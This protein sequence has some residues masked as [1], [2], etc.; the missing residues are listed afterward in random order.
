M[1]LCPINHR[2][3]RALDNAWL[4]RDKAA[5]LEIA[6]LSASGL[7]R[8]SLQERLELARRYKAKWERLYN[9][10]FDEAFGP[11][12]IESPEPAQPEAI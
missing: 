12:E 4:W 2:R 1:R 5:D 6:L 3:H 8:I 9:L 11:F 10:Y 7:A